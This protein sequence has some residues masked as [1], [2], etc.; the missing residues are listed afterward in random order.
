MNGPLS[1]ARQ[2]EERAWME[3]GHRILRAPVADEMRQQLT[4]R[5]WA[6]LSRTA[7]HYMGQ[8]DEEDSARGALAAV[9]ELAETVDQVF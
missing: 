7:V 9:A 6:L 2:R 1:P 3:L 8:L 5:E 4:D